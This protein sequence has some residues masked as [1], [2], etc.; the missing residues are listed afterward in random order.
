VL[1]DGVSGG[2]SGPRSG[3]DPPLD[4][5]PVSIA[6]GSARTGRQYGGDV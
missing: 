5:G 4:I 1:V 3:R 6:G 2:R